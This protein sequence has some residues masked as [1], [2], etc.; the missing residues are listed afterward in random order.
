MSRQGTATAGVR[1]NGI[2]SSALILCA[3]LMTARGVLTAGSDWPLFL[4]NSDRN[5]IVGSDFDPPLEVEWVYEAPGGVDSTAIIVDG[6]VYFG[7]MDGR[8]HAVDL[9]TGEARWIYQAN[10]GVPASGCVARGKVFF[11]D[12]EG[13][14]HAVDIETGEAAWVYQAFAEILSSPHCSDEAVLVGSYDTHLYA[15][16]PTT[17]QVLWKYQTDDR[18]NSSPAVVGREDVHYRL[19]RQ[20]PRH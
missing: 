17:G 8:F 12:E 4:G 2:F 20:V 14:F 18:V 1:A 3:A 10:L 7:E 16:E 5:A 13:F 6:T 19:R 15:F 11:G 9:E